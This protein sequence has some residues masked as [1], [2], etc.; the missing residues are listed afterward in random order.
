M[1][2]F[3]KTYGCQ[4]N[5]ADSE[6]MAAHLETL[7]YKPVETPDKAGIIIVNTCSV[8]LHPENAA[9][10]FL[11]RVKP[12]K[13][14]RPDTRVIFAGCTAQRLK[15][16]I[17]KRFPVIDLVVGAKEI[18]HF[19]E[20]VRGILKNTFVEL[21]ANPPLSPFVKG[22]KHTP[23]SAFVTIM[24]GCENFCSYC[25]VPLVRGP[26]ISRP[27]NEIVADI[28]SLVKRG[29]REVTLLGQNVN[30]YKTANS[31]QLSAVSKDIDFPELL[32]MINSI[33]GLERIRFMTSHPK[34]LSEGLI[35][36]MASLDKVCKHLHLPLQSGSDKILKAMNRGYTR[37]Q[38]LEK[39]HNIRSKMPDISITTDILVG[40]PGETE[41]DFKDTLKAIKE[42]G[43]DSLY[44]FK[45]SARPGTKAFV[46][47]DN[48]KL[49]TKENRLKKTLELGNDISVAKNA[50]LLGKI[51]EVLVDSRA[52]NL[53]QGST[54]TYRKISF[55][56]ANDLTGKV[57]RVKITRV[58]FNSLS[59][60]K[61]L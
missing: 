23:V 32:R 40:F 45:Y 21:A 1:K 5:A 60:T 14:A 55:E 10:S 8:R 18:E 51:E 19:P 48:V 26:E 6:F 4:M 27:A 46:L 11:G 7:G 9:L 47:T 54:S 44:G 38:Y 12:F 61:V 57:A 52:G 53:H 34:D 16:T 17:K 58:K 43:F 35:D 20:L 24:R 36:T 37:S 13:K 49:E 2:Y 25:V 15:D 22:E 41:K 50:K 42:A 59:G 31:R 28:K 56:S 33:K 29:T 3:I 39:I 30:S